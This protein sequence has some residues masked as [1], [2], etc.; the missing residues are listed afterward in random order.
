MCGHPC[1]ADERQA[2]LRDTHNIDPTARALRLYFAPPVGE[3]E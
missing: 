2:H 1:F 3:T